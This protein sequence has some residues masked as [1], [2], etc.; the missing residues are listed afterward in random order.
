M[1]NLWLRLQN[2]V[3]LVAILGAVFLMAQQFG[4][5]IPQNIQ[6]GVNTF[7]YILVLLGIVNDPTTSVL[8][9][10][11]RALEYKEPSKE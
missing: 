2:K 1:I 3:T 8:S 7:I 10:S 4:F 11:A 5:E 9:D 6:A